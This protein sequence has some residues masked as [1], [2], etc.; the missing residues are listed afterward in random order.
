MQSSR[1]NKWLENS[2]NGHINQETIVLVIQ[3]NN[4]PHN[5][6]DLQRISYHNSHNFTLTMLDTTLKY[7]HFKN[8][9]V[10]TNGVEYQCLEAIKNILA[11][12]VILVDDKQ[13][14]IKM[15]EL[16]KSKTLDAQNE[17]KYTL[18][19]KIDLEEVLKQDIQ[20]L[21]EY[22]KLR[23]HYIQKLNSHLRVIDFTLINHYLDIYKQR[24]ILLASFAQVLYRLASL[25]FIANEKVI[26]CELRK[27]LGIKS[28]VISFKSL[29]LDLPMELR[30]NHR[31]YDLNE[32]PSERKLKLSIAIELLLLNSKDVDVQKISKILDLPQKQIEKMYS[33]YILK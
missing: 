3:Q 12:N 32:N 2:Y 28:T 30:K 10:V 14:I 20:S 25:N 29:N 16:L 27:V 1:I 5:L 33:K 8:S 4:P 21:T 26:G 6:G 19:E 23:H 22:V 11:K 7:R 24:N 9:I 13:S 17:I 18:V 15:V 31:V